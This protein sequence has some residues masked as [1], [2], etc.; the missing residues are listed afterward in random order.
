M[1]AQEQTV[2]EL[3]AQLISPEAFEPFGQL[4]GPTHDGK[5][6]DQED[7][8]LVLDKGTPRFYIM[9]LPKRGLCFSRITYHASVTQC[10][11]GLN[12]GQPWYMVVAAPSGSVAAYPQ[13]QQLVAF[14]VP[15]G[16]FLKMKEGTWHAGPLFDGAEQMDFYNLELSDTN[17]V[18]HNTHDYASANG[19]TYRVLDC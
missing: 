4:I 15:H 2:V 17:V 16:V 3:Q 19:V 6:F 1:A 7:A 8:Q 14:K 13:Q 11:G 18:D 5:E 12:P 10:L 9:R